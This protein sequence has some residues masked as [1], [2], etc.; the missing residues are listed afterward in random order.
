MRQAQITSPL[1]DERKLFWI[2][3]F[4]RPEHC[5]SILDELQFAFWS[6]STV[7]NYSPWRESRDML[8]P[9]RISE[10]TT[11][12]WFTP[13]LRRTIRSIDRRLES[14]VP[15]FR[16]RREDWQATRYGIGGKF[17]YHL[18]AGHWPAERGGNREHTVLIYLSTP[19]RGGGT[20]F[21]ELDL[22]VQAR[23]GRLLVW[24]NM[25]DR[26]E[27]DLDMLHAATP[28]VAGRKVVLVT[29]VRQRTI[30]KP[31]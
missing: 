5:E 9:I 8:S 11:E 19:R 20:H 4:L 26:T 23:T 25:I 1:P 22:D 7:T 28:L 12:K 15:H 27:R 3:S 13:A 21:R 17:D 14:L 6:P 18:D 16:T 30:R 10:T 24:R 29:W 2:E 31:T